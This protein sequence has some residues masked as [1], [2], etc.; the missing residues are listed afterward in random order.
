MNDETMS[1]WSDPGRIPSK[2]LPLAGGSSL[3]DVDTLLA[4]QLPLPWCFSM[5]WQPGQPLPGAQHLPRV[6]V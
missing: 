1:A 5:P 2:W 3:R 6:A 4:C